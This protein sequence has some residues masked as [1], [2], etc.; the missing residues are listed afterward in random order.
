MHKGIFNSDSII[1][2]NI[3]ANSSSE[4]LV[5]GDQY[6]KIL[7]G[8]IP[9]VTSLVFIDFDWSTYS[10]MFVYKVDLTFENNLS[11]TGSRYTVT[12]L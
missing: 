7:P 6:G 10:A 11:H 2:W 5:L 1:I 3:S 12:A 4:P 8:R 9:S